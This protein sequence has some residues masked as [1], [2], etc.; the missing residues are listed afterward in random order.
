VKPTFKE[1]NMKARVLT[2]TALCWLLFAVELIAD[3]VAWLAG[4]VSQ[5]AGEAAEH[6]AEWGGK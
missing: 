3:A 2:A 5:I 6:V 1:T 4:K